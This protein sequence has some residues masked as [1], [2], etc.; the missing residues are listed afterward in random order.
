MFISK[1][2]VAVA[3]SEIVCGLRQF[4]LALVVCCTQVINTNIHQ[5]KL[6]SLFTNHF[7]LQ[8]TQKVSGGGSSGGS[9]CGRIESPFFDDVLL[10]VP[11]SSTF[12]S[13]SGHRHDSFSSCGSH[14]LLAPM[15][16]VNYDASSTVSIMQDIAAGGG[17]WPN[18]PNSHSPAAVSAASGGSTSVSAALHRPVSQSPLHRGGG[19]RRSLKR[20]SSTREADPSG[21]IFRLV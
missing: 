10:D 20:D 14:S 6:P 9:G 5:L 1:R 4:C 16:S 2:G 13:S 3:G 11:V 18:Q 19:G 21:R 17:A 7:P 8:L 15:N 12:G